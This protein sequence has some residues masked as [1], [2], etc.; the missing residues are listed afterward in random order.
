[1]PNM[2]N[3]S[4]ASALPNETWAVVRTS[5]QGAV[6]SMYGPW[7][8]LFSARQHTLVWWSGRQGSVVSV[9]P[10]VQTHRDRSAAPIKYHPNR[11]PSIRDA[12]A[13]LYALGH[14][15]LLSIFYWVG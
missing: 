5:R 13:K 8:A 3:G 10:G 14:C 9:L 4:V 6:M 15:D 2:G 11:P 1:M 12:G 7:G